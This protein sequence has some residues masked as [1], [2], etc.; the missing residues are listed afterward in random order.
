VHKRNCFISQFDRNK[1][2]AERGEAIV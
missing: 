1:W 2:V